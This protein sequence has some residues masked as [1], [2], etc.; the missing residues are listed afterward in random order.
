MTQ[1][2]F[3]MA[4]ILNVPK[5]IRED[6]TI[7]CNKQEHVKH[8]ERENK[9]DN[10]DLIFGAIDDEKPSREKL[11]EKSSSIDEGIH[12]PIDGEC[13]TSSISTVDDECDNILPIT[14]GD[15]LFNL[16]VHLKSISGKNSNEQN[17]GMSN[18]RVKHRLHRHS[19]TNTLGHWK[20]AMKKT[21]HLKDPWEDFKI[22]H[23]PE[24]IVICHEFDPIKRTWHTS[25]ITVKIESKPFAH[26]SMR[27]CFRLKQLSIFSTNQDWDRSSNYIA[28]RYIDDVPMARYFDDVMMQMTT[29]ARE[30]LM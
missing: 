14:E 26:G 5:S 25:Q 18:F 20:E 29:R 22:D 27:E 30:S 11:N 23:Y 6:D 19:K 21:F 1:K 13:T 24:E 3:H 15:R 12:L 28:K 10:G 2:M 4:P 8:K 17:V 7:C 16:V 9:E